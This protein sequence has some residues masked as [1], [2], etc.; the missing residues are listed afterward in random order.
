MKSTYKEIKELIDR[1][2]WT[3]GAFRVG[4]Q[5]TNVHALGYFTPASS[6]WSYRLGVAR[7]RDGNVYHVVTV[8]GVVK[9]FERIW[10]ADTEKAVYSL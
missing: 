6:N 5:P 1:T 10:L 9:G 3:A 8:Y 4:D 7:G 2:D